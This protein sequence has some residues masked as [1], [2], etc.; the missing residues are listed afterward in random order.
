MTE[1]TCMHSTISYKVTECLPCQ[2]HNNNKQWESKASQENQEG[3]AGEVSKKQVR[4][5]PKPGPRG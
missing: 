2:F 3:F 4:D 1:H 5:Q